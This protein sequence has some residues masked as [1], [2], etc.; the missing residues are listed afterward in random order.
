MIIIIYTFLKSA[1][2]INKKSANFINKKSASLDNH[3]QWE[4]VRD[5][6]KK[7]RDWA[8]KKV[9]VWAIVFS[10]KTVRDWANLV[11]NWIIAII[12]YMEE[13]CDEKHVG[14]QLDYKLIKQE[15]LH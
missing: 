3:V 10:S 9:Q 2:F 14:R 13:N 4:K 1:N 8:I 7:V 15:S 11:R 6:T 12:Q 5:W